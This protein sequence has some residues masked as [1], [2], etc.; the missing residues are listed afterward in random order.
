MRFGI[1]LLVAVWYSTG[2]S[3]VKIKGKVADQH[4]NPIVSATISTPDNLRASS[5]DID[6]S[7]E[8][9]LSA[10]D[11]VIIVSHV[12][13]DTAYVEVKGRTFLNIVLNNGTRTLKEV[14]IFHTGYQSIPRERATGSFEQIH[15]KDIQKRVSS[16]I[17]ERLEGLVP[18]LQF[19]N[20]SGDANINPKINIRGIN[21]MSDNMMEPLIVV[22]NFPFA[23]NINDINPNDVESVT[24]L[25]DAAAASIWGAKAGNGVIVINLKKPMNR[26]QPVQVGFSSNLSILEKARLM[27]IPQISSSDFIDVERFLFDN[28]FYDATYNNP[29]YSKTTIF[30]PVVDLL[31]DHQK[32]LISDIELQSGLDAYR[33][34][35]YRDDLLRYF[36]RNNTLQQSNLSLTGGNQVNAWRF[37]L[38]YDKILADRKG[39]KSN[40]LTTNFQNTLSLGSKLKVEI[41]SRLTRS[42]NSDQSANFTYDYKMGSKNL[43]PYADLVGDKGQALIVP[44]LLNVR[45]AQSLHST[46]LLDWLYRPYEEAGRTSRNDT[47]NHIVSQLNLIYSPINGLNLSLHYNNE[48]QQEEQ[49]MV[50]LEDSFFA[51][52]TINRFSQVNGNTVNYVVPNAGIRDAGNSYVTGH[53]LRGGLAFNRSFKERTHGMSAILGAELSTTTSKGNVSRNYGYQPAVMEIQPV[54]YVNLYPSYDGLFGNGR[55]PYYGGYSKLVNRFVSF[56]G[57][58]SYT[59]SEKYIASLSARRDASNIFGVKTNDRWKPLWSSGLS[60]LASRES[61]LKDIQWLSNLKLRATYGHSGNSGGVA[62]SYPLIFHQAAINTSLSGAPFAQ[63]FSLPNPTM[64]WE[65]VEMLNFGL[66]F[67]VFG[68]KL[69]G[70]AEFFSKKATDLISSDQ[71]DPT[72][73]MATIVRNVGKMEG[74]GF[75]IN[76]Q[77]DIDLGNVR[78]TGK[79]FL[80]HSISKVTEYRGNVGLASTYLPNSGTRS[81]PLPD[82]ELYPVFGLRFA[83]LDPD[84]GDPIGYYDGAESKEYAS[85]LR[86]SLQN[87][88]YFGSGLPPY[89][90]SFGHNF[91]WRGFDFSFLMMFKF[92]HFFQKKSIRYNNLFNN[93]EG[94]SDFSERWQ[95][96][97]D[98]QY[99]AIPSMIYPG[100]PDRDNFYAYSEANIERGD[101]LRL[102]DVR[103]SYTFQ[104][105]RGNRKINVSVF[106][107]LNNIGILWRANTE[108]LDP[109]YGTIPPSRRISFGLNCT[110]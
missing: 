28:G 103:L 50:Y 78:W 4:S 87:I 58:T 35:D 90:G 85:M 5:S 84:N 104:H 36:Y 59:Y 69:S 100:N 98:E 40:R 37:S 33:A 75:D 108:G 7:F 72:L 20:R 16:N 83:G 80:S 77:A 34:I 79:L 38:G 86:D 10:S 22:D 88:L 44:N 21:T 11:S 19:D 12:G 54:D 106:S 17:M 42:H 43:Y 57:N 73:G 64:K 45:Y 25:K 46:P 27:D 62:S 82:R 13:F 47:R 9:E 94:H 30:T 14:D 2:L 95:N 67:G 39:L 8:L 32:G 97:G 76:L 48:I 52:N 109:D 110:F 18:G 96:P 99:T 65:N 31:F 74:K 41:V 3:Q 71:I 93:W 6:G 68:N 107:A 55:I 24:L 1:L 70:S 49:D 92:G 105:A 60:W 66:D 63:M 81:D 91:T 15:N 102:Q 29:V 101:V 23:G 56:Y 61:F 51:R 53:R 89:Y 26:E